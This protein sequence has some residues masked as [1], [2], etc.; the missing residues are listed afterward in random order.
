MAISKVE[1]GKKGEELAVKYL[2]KQG[3]RILEKNYRCP[4]GE[5]DIIARDGE[6]LVF[7]EVKTRKDL[8]FGRPKEAIGYRKRCQISK[9][10]QYFLKE[11]KY[12]HLS[13]RFDVLE[14]QMDELGVRFELI[15]DAF[16]LPTH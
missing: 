7:V 14:V 6:I 11:R 3:Y 16:E 12:H 2:S 9:V 10:A 5:V 13:A 8:S 15:M 1:V 4:L